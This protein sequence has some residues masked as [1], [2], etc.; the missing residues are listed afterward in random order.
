MC[1]SSEVTL[2]LR[3]TNR[4]YR[5]PI[6]GCCPTPWSLVVLKD[7][8]GVL[9]PGLE[10]LLTSLQFSQ[11][12]LWIYTNNL[13]CQKLESLTETKLESVTYIFAPTSIGLRLL[14]FTQLLS[15]EVEPSESKT[16]VTK[17]KFD[18]KYPLHPVL[19]PGL[20]ASVL[21]NLPAL[22]PLP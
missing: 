8:T 15:L 11:K 9:G 19:G 13:H 21:V 17:T 18:M 12:S 6:Q 22:K 10:F 7:K 3:R 14:F 1:V 4:L 16:A 20:E 5:T 2:N